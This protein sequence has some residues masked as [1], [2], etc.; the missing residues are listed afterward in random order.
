MALVEEELPGVN[1]GERKSQISSCTT[2]MTVNFCCVYVLNFCTLV[3]VLHSSNVCALFCVQSAL[4][5]ECEKT[6]Q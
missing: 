2:V 5:F 1:K 4:I 3:D 6:A